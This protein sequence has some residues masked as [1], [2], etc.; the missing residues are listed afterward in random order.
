MIFVA[1]F[2]S[3]TKEKF[4]S[5]AN[6]HQT[7]RTN[8]IINKFIIHGICSLITPANIS[9]KFQIPITLVTEDENNSAKLEN[10][11]SLSNLKTK[12]A[13][14]KVTESVTKNCITVIPKALLN[15]FHLNNIN[16]PVINNTELTHHLVHMIIA[17]K[18]FTG[19]LRAS[20]NQ[21]NAPAIG[22]PDIVISVIK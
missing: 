6:N 15:D 8:Q 1:F 13:D 14:N 5:K 17:I 9:I 16:N 18:L 2:F 19:I 20:H 4:L 7:K 21:I 22:E 11:S 12:V 10:T 3:F